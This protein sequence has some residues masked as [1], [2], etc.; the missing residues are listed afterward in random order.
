MSSGGN[1]DIATPRPRR[2]RRILTVLADVLLACAILDPRTGDAAATVLGDDV[3]EVLGLGRGA[4]ALVLT[5]DRL[6]HVKGN[7]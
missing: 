7:P 3:R 2:G 1:D 4:G 5:S 6:I